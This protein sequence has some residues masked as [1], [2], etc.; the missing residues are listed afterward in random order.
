[1][2]RDQRIAA[3]LFIGFII[4]VV[5]F[6]TQWNYMQEGEIIGKW[7]S[8]ANILSLVVAIPFYFWKKWKSDNDKKN[9]ASKN[10]YGELNDALD[11]LDRK[12]HHSSVIVVAYTI[13]EEKSEKSSSKN[14]VIVFINR[15]LNHDI[16]DSLIY[17]GEI[18]FLTY[19]VQQESQDI[20]KRIKDHNYYLRYIHKIMNNDNDIKKLIDS[21]KWLQQNDSKILKTIPNLM[22]KLKEDFK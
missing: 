21:C 6:L 14:E 16:Y 22:K 7:A 15:F 20:F 10:L 2:L 1:M 12:K 13:D 11:G 17:S 5:C 8:V 4:I 9:R 18:N 19:K 3:G